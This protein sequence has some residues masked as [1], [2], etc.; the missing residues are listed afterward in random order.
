M[1]KNIL[2]IFIIIALLSACKKESN[3]NLINNYYF[4]KI[5]NVV[6]PINITGNK[7]AEQAII[8]INDGL[9]TN[10]NNEKNNIYWSYIEKNYKVVYFD[11]RGSGTAQ[12]NAKPE[13]MTIEQFARDLDKVVDFTFQIAKVKSVFLHGVGIG[14][15]V[16]CQYLLD[17]T[18]QNKINGFIAEAPAYNMVDALTLSKLLVLQMADSNI[19]KNSNI[20]YWQSK[21]D[22]Y[23]A[24]PLFTADVFNEHI[25]ILQQNNGIIF[26]AN[27]VK[28]RSTDAPNT[29]VDAVYKNQLKSYSD[30]KYNGQYFTSLNLTPLLNKIDIP[31]LLIWGDK[32]AFLPKNNLAIQFRNAIGANVSYNPTKYLLTGHVPHAED[33]LTFQLDANAFINAN[34]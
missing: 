12:G 4:L 25:N 7:F 23:N 31:I 11:Q 17:S 16:A 34:K 20:P 15:T 19:A 28:Q 30:I 18:K 33:F 9:T 22:Y 13:D 26:N 1:K 5:D 3:S 24:H 8:Y 21:I 10:V 32:D 27:N 6:L 2:Y 29:P 14:G